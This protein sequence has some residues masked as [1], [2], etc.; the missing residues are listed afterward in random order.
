MTKDVMVVTGVGG[1]GLAVARRMGSGVKLVLSDYDKARLEAAAATLSA[2][3]YDV[4]PVAMDVSDREAVTSLAETASSL[5]TVKVLVHTAGVSWLQA[6]ASAPIYRINLLG[7]AWMLDA[8][9]RIA[10]P[11]MTAVFTSSIARL[12][13]KVTPELADSLARLPAGELP[14]LV[15]GELRNAP[16]TDPETAYS[17][18]KVC[19]YDRVRAAAIAWGACGARLNTISPGGVATIMGRLSMD[20]SDKAKTMLAITPL[21]RVGTPE[22]IAMATEFLTSS[23]SM[24]ITGTDLLVDGGVFAA[25]KFGATPSPR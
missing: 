5:G 9:G 24:F 16:W 19:I 11:G 3:G 4:M 2:D 14:A 6:G 8:F 22:D 10:T 17:V 18:S 12:F 7:T 23:Q 25:A 15:E 13:T 20:E 21:E 1:I